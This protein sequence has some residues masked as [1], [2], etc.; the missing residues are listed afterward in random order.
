[1]K[2]LFLFLS[3]LA[4]TNSFSQ[5]SLNS[6]S[7]ADL[8]YSFTIENNELKGTGG[9]FL[10]EKIAESQFTMMGEYHGS[11][12]ISLLTKALIPI[13]DEANYET[14]IAEI[15]PYSA[16]VLTSISADAGTTTTELKGFNDK[17]TYGED[18]YTAIPFF[19][20]KVD[21][22]FF[23]E[24]AK[25]KWN[26][27]GIDQEF[28]YGYPMLF[29]HMFAEIPAADQPTHASAY[30]RVQDTLA[31]FITLDNDTKAKFELLIRDSEFLTDFMES[32]SGYGKNMEIQ[33][34]LLKSIDIY[35]L[36][37]TRQWYESNRDRISYMKQNTRKGF[38]KNN[39]DFTKDKAF[40]KMGAY[41]LSKGYSPLGFFEVGNM[42]N[43]MAD[44]HG[45]KAFNFKFVSRYY[46]ED[47][48]VFD[49]AAE[50]SDLLNLIKMGKKD[51]WT[52][53][54]LHPII[55]GVEFYPVKYILNPAEQKLIESYDVLII[56]PVDWEAERL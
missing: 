56:P 38:E 49:D 42:L 16:E 13:L 17:Y 9:D 51:E 2:Y 46:K 55:K 8:T 30:S 7:L 23:K 54:N 47:G 11:H 41:H 1:M 14:I 28:I 33:T 12:Q 10:K 24:I 18:R 20:N 53:I 48:E 3:I 35:A 37:S 32:V 40:I 31:H 21:A 44:Y 27:V 6:T 50:P 5:D 45:N 25:A 52:V 19:S 22:D 36:N 4:F 34:A 39:F 15:G 29:D 26:I 43:E